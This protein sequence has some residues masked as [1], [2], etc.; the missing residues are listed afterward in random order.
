MDDNK[1]IVRGNQ[2]LCSD[3]YTTSHKSFL[4]LQFLNEVIGIICEQSWNY[5]ELSV[6]I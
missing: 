4:A 3:A 1:W 5:V 2:V 6:N